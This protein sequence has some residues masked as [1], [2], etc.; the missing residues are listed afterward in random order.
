[1]RFQ[2]EEGLGFCCL[3]C[4]S[5]SHSRMRDPGFKLW[6]QTTVWSHLCLLLWE[7]SWEDLPEACSPTVVWVALF[8]VVG[9][10]SPRDAATSL[11]K[12]KQ[13]VWSQ[14]NQRAGAYRPSCW[15]V[16]LLALKLWNNFVGI[17]VPPKLHYRK[18]CNL[19]VF[20]NLELRVE[21]LWKCMSILLIL[22]TLAL[23]F[24]FSDWV[25]GTL[26]SY[27]GTRLWFFLFISRGKIWIV[28][29]QGTVWVH[30]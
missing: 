10:Y 13:W 17:E 18:P 24:L 19:F 21:I 23:L 2:Q 15:G 25:K 1:M 5:Q 11:C 27:V 9:P 7:Y 30:L 26:S 16:L 8:Q 29:G 14:V 4:S 3:L 6:F 12:N 20:L 28:S 22:E